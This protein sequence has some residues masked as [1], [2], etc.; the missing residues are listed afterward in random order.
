M[1]AACSTSAS[2]PAIAP[3]IGPELHALDDAAAAH[4][5]DLN[6]AAAWPDLQAEHVA[7][8][9]PGTR[10]LLL[11]IAQRLDR[12]QR[13]TQLRRLLEPLLV[14]GRLHPIPQTL[15]QLVVPSFEQ[16]PRVGDGHAVLLFG[17]DLGHTRAPGSA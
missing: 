14:R 12:P 9:E 3:G 8:A 11:P 10:H 17:A 16:Q 4:L 15:D 5:E 13:I 7:I 6:R 2:S 1:S